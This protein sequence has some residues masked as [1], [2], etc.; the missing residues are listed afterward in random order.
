MRYDDWLMAGTFGTLG[1][2]L[3]KKIIGAGKPKSRPAKNTVTVPLLDMTG[4]NADK[5]TKIP[6][7]WPYPQSDDLYT[8]TPAKVVQI[9]GANSGKKRYKVV[10]NT[11]AIEWVEDYP[12]VRGLGVADLSCGKEGFLEWAD[13]KGIYDEETG[14]T[15]R[16]AKTIS[17]FLR[18]SVGG[19][20]DADFKQL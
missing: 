15:Y 5:F 6:N 13:I 2:W 17:E 4:E 18:L 7:L 10:L 16:A 19:I 14:K 11:V 9:M 20:I 3:I 12:Y 1:I 8:C